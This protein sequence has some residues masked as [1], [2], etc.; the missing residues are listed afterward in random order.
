MSSR[1]SLL[2]ITAILALAAAASAQVSTYYNFSQS[3]G[4]YSPLSGGTQIAVAT[5]TSG[6]AS[7]DDVA[8]SVALPF[9]F[10]FD[11]A[12]YSS[13][14]ANTNGSITFGATLPG[15]N[16]SPLSST[17]AYNGAIAAFAADLQAGYVFKCDRVTGTNTLTNV[18]STGPIQVGDIL[19]GTGIPTGT[20]ITAIAG[21]TITMS[22]NATSTGTAGAAGAVGPWAEMRYETLGT[23]PNQV[24]VVQW[25]NFKRFSFT[26]LTAVELS[27][28]FQIRLHEN[29]GKIEVV[30]GNCSP[31]QATTTGT[32]QV[33]LRGPTNAFPTNI[34]NR[35]NTKGVNDDWANSVIGTANSSGMLFNNVSP[36]NVIT[37]GLTYDWAP[38]IGIP[39]TNTSY[40]TG[41]Y[42]VARD[43]FYDLQST[44]AAASAEFSNTSISMAFT[45]NGYVVTGNTA[46]FV[47]PTGLATSFTLTDDS[48]V[49]TPAL[50]SP[51]PYIG[52]SAGTLTVCS[53]GFVSVATGNG[54][55]FAP[56]P[57]TM[58]AAPQA[59]FWA[60]HDFNP[61]AVGSGAVKFEEVGGIAYVTWDGV[62][63]YL[64]TTAA[65]AN[66]MQF[67]FEL[68]TGNV[69]IVF[70]T[71]ST[72]GGTGW[73]T[74]YS[75]GGANLDPGSI[76]F[77]TALPIVTAPDIYS[78][79]LSVNATPVLGTSIVYTTSNIP[80]TAVISA[81]I[82]SLIQM[83][84]GTD[85][86]NLGAPG[87]LQLVDLSLS[88]TSFL[89]GSPTATF[90]LS[91][92]NDPG[93]AGLP[94]NLQS[95]SLVP[96]VNP[97]GLLTS[98]GVRSVV[99]NF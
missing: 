99:G 23:A 5:G 1:K 65:D 64:G 49:T 77:A 86:G 58:L 78:L 39:A 60:Q 54:T 24:F 8:Y 95:A 12:A 17:T 4:T 11:G 36:A 35:L 30:Y 62:Y 15:S 68:A 6:A 42:T 74:G 52:G 79:A 61:A 48:E 67:Q 73:L 63:N 25:Q 16:Y 40:G 80:L 88:S 72:T 75:T 91:V 56:T 70:G 51:F 27:L 37:S 21:N 19:G 7:L 55:G 84:P 69:N 20:T 94:L 46:T 96:G 22:A 59:G 50:S 92:P 98:N 44:A 3:A 53:N 26:S 41:C 32:C 66:T 14:Y 28:N 93:I 57:A 87:C 9:S 71:L 47:P 85:L 97:I 33:G 43:S 18:S 10:T 34:N 38:N 29:D 2:S 45:G 89:L 81:Q 83:N 90:S 31:G 76:S 82:V 13:I